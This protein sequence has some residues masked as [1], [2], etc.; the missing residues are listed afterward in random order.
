MISNEHLTAFVIGFLIPFIFPLLWEMITD[1]Y[2][3]FKK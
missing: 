2:F 1:I 3:T